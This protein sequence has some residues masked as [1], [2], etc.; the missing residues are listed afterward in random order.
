MQRIRFIQALG[1]ALP[2]RS[3]SK[4]EPFTR[5]EIVGKALLLRC[6]DPG[7]MRGRSSDLDLVRLVARRNRVE[8][9]R[10]V[11]D[12]DF[13]RWRAEKLSRVKLGKHGGH[14]GGI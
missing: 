12:G 13:W 6:V 11:G 8:H 4:R 2:Q 1:D 9:A 7:V 3:G 14:A 5:I 10:S